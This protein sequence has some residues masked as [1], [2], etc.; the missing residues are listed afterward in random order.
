MLAQNI[1]YPATR[2]ETR[3]PNGMESMKSETTWI[4]VADGDQARFFL[5]IRPGVRLT[6]LTDLAL[7][8]A[9]ERR[10]RRHQTAVKDGVDRGH[11]VLPAHLNRQDEEEL[12][13]LAHVAGRINLAVEEHA[14]GGLV[15]CAP[16]S[17]LGSLRNHLTDPALQL[18]V[19]ELPKDIVREQIAE[20]EARLVSLKV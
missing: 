7:T 3:V 5:R 17:A 18:I 6:E 1:A 2:I 15:L 16:P 9:K 8:A 13:F 19:E 10:L 11:H 12:H 14:V 4:V 20:I